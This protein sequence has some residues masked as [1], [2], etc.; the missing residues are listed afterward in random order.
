[1]L[2]NYL[3]QFTPAGLASVGFAGGDVY[4]PGSRRYADPAAYL[5][6][7]E[8]WEPQRT[9]FCRL[10]GRSADPSV[11]LA[12]VV[13]ELNTAVGEL[14]TVLA[15]R[16]GPVRL[17]GESGDLVISPLTAEDV[18]AEAIAL[19]AEPTEM[20]PFAPIVSLLIET[21]RQAAKPRGDS[22]ERASSLASTRIVDV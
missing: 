2:G 15:E 20:L 22:V 3:R 5:L 14:E 12:A 8:Q 18:P 6:T 4:V 13:E 17:D 9:E 10:V 7:S 19:K 1:M 16:E 11:A 21:P